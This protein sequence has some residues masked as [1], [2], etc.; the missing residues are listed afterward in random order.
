MDFLFL[1]LLLCYVPGKWIRHFLPQWKLTYHILLNIC[2]AQMDG[3]FL[4]KMLNYSFP[5][6]WTLP[7]FLPPPHPPSPRHFSKGPNLLL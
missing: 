5:N 2:Q 4:N 6:L 1:Y 3:T 7:T